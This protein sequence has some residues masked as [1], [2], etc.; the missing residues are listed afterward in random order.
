MCCRSLSIIQLP[1]PIDIRDKIQFQFFKSPKNPRIKKKH[2]PKK[3]WR[4]P[5]HSPL[6]SPALPERLWPPCTGATWP[7]RPR[8][9]WVPWAT[10]WLR[11]SLTS[12]DRC[13]I[14]VFSCEML[15]A[16]RWKPGNHQ[17]SM[18]VGVQSPE[19]IHLS[20]GVLE[21]PWLIE[22]KRH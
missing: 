19:E 3:P 14:S 21:V 6:V 2:D 16:P 5:S 18:A 15:L 11:I 9:P 12:L 4:I 8:V 10:A 7:W 22:R 13:C 17:K 1:V 20:M